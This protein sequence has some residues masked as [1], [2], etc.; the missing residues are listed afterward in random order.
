MT[1]NEVQQL[2]SELR[3]FLQDI[4]GQVQMH[5][6]VPN[7]RDQLSA[8]LSRAHRGRWCQPQGGQ[9]RNEIKLGAF[10]AEQSDQRASR[11]ASR[12]HRQG[13]VYEN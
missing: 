13:S 4:F 8:E 11:K 3:E 6:E 12:A 5:A 7:E 1:E 9:H 2:T 10:G